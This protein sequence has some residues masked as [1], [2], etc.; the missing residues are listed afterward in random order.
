MYLFPAVKHIEETK[1]TF[2]LSGGIP[3]KHIKET[4]IF[5]H[6]FF[7]PLREVDDDHVALSFTQDKL[8]H[9]QGYKISITDDHIL[10]TYHKAQGIFYAMQTLKQIYIQNRRGL[11][12]LEISD[13]P[14]LE[15]RGFMLDISRNKVP[16]LRTLKS[17]VDL[18]AS[19]K[20]NH[21]ELYVEGFSYLYPSH[22]SCYDETMTP[23][24]PR[25]YK[26]LE[27]Y[28]KKNMIDLVPCHNGLGH[29]TAWLKK[30]PELAV[31]PDGMFF[32]GAHRDPSTVNPLDPK[33]LELVKSFYEDALKNTKSS[34]FHMNLDEPYELGHGKTEEEGKRIGV[35]Q[36]YLDY[37]LKL[38]GFV[39]D[40]RK[41]PLIWGDVLNHYP[42]LLSQ[43]PKDLIYVDWGYDQDY[44]FYKTL[45]RLGD[46]GVKF[47]AAPGTST[48]NSLTGRHFNM[49]ENIRQACL[50]TKI[51]NGLGMLLTE[52]GDNGHLQPYTQSIPAIAF[53]GMESWHAR[54]NNQ[55]EIKKYIDI[56][57][58][59]D[60]SE[61]T[62]QILIDL[63][64]YH[65]FESSFRYN[66][67]RL[68]DVIYAI[69]RA[70]SL[71][72]QEDMYRE[73][74]TH[75]Y[76][77]VETYRRISRY[78][79]SLDMQCKRIRVLHPKD[80]WQKTEILWSKD[81]LRAMMYIIHLNHHHC[82]NDDFIHHK[83]WL[84]DHYPKILKTF[85]RIWLHFNK[86]GGL[87][88][89]IKPLKTLDLYIK[90][91]QTYNWIER[92]PKTGRLSVFQKKKNAMN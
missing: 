49:I 69:N 53:G 74:S 45:K 75:S 3:F 48:W 40:H 39:K 38:Y 29:M 7:Y 60:P 62:G 11:P 76:G 81:M 25:E 34:Y 65:I 72:L 59:N 24:T 33:S 43:L 57:E 51:N 58:M 88:Q 55:F 68:M 77:E 30:Y 18:I 12:C 66:G 90:E 84:F 79:D 54:I 85:E 46:L 4:E 23:L 52:W 6:I 56:I 9:E 42:E 63:A 19:L 28:A 41:T 64:S 92:N 36:M 17:Y 27:R 14:D 8:L 26:S 67:T 91:I 13:E 70:D 5:D 78:L 71:H 37:V 89:S 87:E 47:M 50:H 44:P 86:P 83:K 31:M 20:Y 35:G 32:W 1:G 10:I 61:R 15:V 22:E 2:D 16:K 82:S 21:F 73:L 80:K